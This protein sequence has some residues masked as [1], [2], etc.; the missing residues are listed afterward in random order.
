[1][2]GGEAKTHGQV[3]FAHSD[4]APTTSMKNLKAFRMLNIRPNI[5]ILY[6]LKI[7]QSIYILMYK[8]VPTN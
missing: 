4:R 1:M 7:V 5:V 6:F 8:S 3:K 2:P